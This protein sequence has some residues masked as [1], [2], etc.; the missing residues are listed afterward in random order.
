M[1]ALWFIQLNEEEQQKELLKLPMTS[2]KTG[3]ADVSKLSAR[4]PELRQ[5]MKDLKIRQGLMDRRLAHQNPSDLSEGKVASE[6]FLG[7]MDS[8]LHSQTPHFTAYTGTVTNTN[9]HTTD[10]K[11]ELESLTKGTEAFGGSISTAGDSHMGGATPGIDGSLATMSAIS[12]GDNSFSTPTGTAVGAINNMIDV[13][14][15]SEDDS[16]NNSQ[17]KKGLRQ[18]DFSPV[19]RRSISNTNSNGNTGD[20]GNSGNSPTSKEAE[21]DMD[22]SST[23]NMN[24]MNMNTMNMTSTPIKTKQASSTSLSSSKMKAMKSPFANKD[25]NDSTCNSNSMRKI[26]NSKNSTTLVA[27]LDLQDVPE[28]SLTRPTRPSPMRK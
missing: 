9:T 2:V 18:L 15:I 19:T 20:G 13:T 28:L 22:L 12:M 6:G 3:K 27:Q 5:R 17:S 4:E 8:D 10:I 14:N 11:N 1:P 26:K 24:T 7:E 23:M 25:G 16:Y 21:V